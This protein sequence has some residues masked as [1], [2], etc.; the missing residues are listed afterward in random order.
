MP[1]NLLEQLRKYTVVVAD[2]GDIEAMK[3]FRPAGRHHQPFADYRRGADAAV[4]AHRGRRA[5][6]S[7]Q[8]TGRG[9][10]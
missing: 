9:G 1:K 5:A 2:T 6:G 7:A 10:R 8:G 3:K 4:S